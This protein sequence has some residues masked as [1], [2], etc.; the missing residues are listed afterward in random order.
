MD[1][2]G[3]VVNWDL[4]RNP[5]DSSVVTE[6]ATAT[7]N[8]RGEAIQTAEETYVHRVGRTARMGRGGVAVSFVTERRWDEGTLKRIEERIRE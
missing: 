6:T 2:V 8:G 3:M 1:G 5:K 4:P 7:V